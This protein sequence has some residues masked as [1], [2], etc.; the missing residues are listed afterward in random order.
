MAITVHVNGAA[1]IDITT[2]TGGTEQLGY[3]ENGVTINTNIATQDIFTDQFGQGVPTDV[4]FLGEQGTVD[5]ELLSWDW[6]VL[7]RLLSPI[8]KVVLNTPGQVATTDYGCLY[9]K[10][11]LTYGL[12]INAVKT[13]ERSYTFPA[14]FLV[15]QR[16]LTIGTRESRWSLTFRVLPEVSGSTATLYTTTTI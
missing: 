6:A 14:A 8:D 16:S 13:G 5:I 7:N 10:D 12:K 4:L 2:F 11:V 1:R 15:D 9:A 3:S